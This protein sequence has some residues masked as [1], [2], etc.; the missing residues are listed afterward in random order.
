MLATPQI[1][2]KHD[3]YMTPKSAWTAIKDYIPQNGIIW[4][5]FFGDGTSGTYLEELG[6][7]IW[8]EDEDFFEV[9]DWPDTGTIVTNPPFSKIKKILTR[10]KQ[11]GLP[12]IMIMPS[13]KIC[14]QY[15][16]KLFGDCMEQDPIQ[17]IIPRKRIHFIKKIW[18]SA[19]ITY[20][21]AETQGQAPFDCF[22]YCWKIGLPKD[23]IW[24]E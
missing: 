4:D 14:T 20:H 1:Y 19:C 23:I 15:F 5:P 2:H 6:H 18:C 16:R 3:D 9:E 22:Y 17:I 11:I 12:F 21:D 24:L 13:T 7:D 8:H 10:L